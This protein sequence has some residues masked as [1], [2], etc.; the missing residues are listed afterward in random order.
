MGSHFFKSEF[1]FPSNPISC[2][3]VTDKQ[4]W[5]SKNSNSILVWA[6][7][8]RSDRS[9]KYLSRILP[10]HVFSWIRRIRICTVYNSKRKGF[11]FS[12]SLK[13]SIRRSFGSQRSRGRETS[14]NRQKYQPDQWRE[15]VVR[16]NPLQRPMASPSTAL[17]GYLSPTSL[18]PLQHRRRKMKETT[19]E[20]LPLPPHLMPPTYFWSFLEEAVGRGGVVC[21]MHLSSLDSIFPLDLFRIDRYSDFFFFSF[22]F[23]Y[24]F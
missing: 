4:T 19:K 16:S 18:P 15:A 3:P 23:W 24:T 9:V 10:C 21:L 11:W 6:K 13:F 20:S 5:L 7:S 12:S 8:S 2:N 1:P 22:K 14:E 17:G